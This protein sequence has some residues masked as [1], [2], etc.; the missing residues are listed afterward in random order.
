MG[1]DSTDAHLA[2]DIGREPSAH[3]S[4]ASSAISKSIMLVATCLTNSYFFHRHII[5]V[6]DVFVK[7]IHL[8]LD[9]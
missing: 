9:K 7:K 3:P 1:V 5:H 6:R 4:I 2:L 8:V